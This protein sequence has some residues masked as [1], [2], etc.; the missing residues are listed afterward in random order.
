LGQSH[1]EKFEAAGR[2]NLVVQPEQVVLDCVL[3][4]TKALRNFAIGESFR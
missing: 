4:Q 3:A 2:A 1:E